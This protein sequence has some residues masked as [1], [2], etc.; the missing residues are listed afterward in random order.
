MK[1]VYVLFFLMIVLASVVSASLGTYKMNDCVNIVVPI[2]SSSV[3]LTNVNTPAPNSTIILSNKAMTANGNLFNYT[4]CNTSIMGTYTY[5]YCDASGNCYGNDFKINGSGQDVSQSQITL[6][7]VGLVIM[8]IFSAFFFIL[9]FL[10]QHPGTK[11]FLMA[12]S[13]LTL[14]VLI[15]VIT[16]N[17]TVYLAEFPSIV[18][19]YN[20]YYVL[21]VIFAGVAMIGILLWLIYYS[22]TLFNKTRGRMPED[23]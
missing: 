2:N 9:S 16:A 17:A 21:M 10:F 18:S 6:I 22:F 7:I 20:N 14:I 8:L 3:T 23:D 19:F 12:L 13:A 4:F 11:I 15:G 1:K 5:G